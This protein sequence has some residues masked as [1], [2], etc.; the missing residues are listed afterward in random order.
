MKSFH[1]R[2]AGT[3]LAALMVVGGTMAGASPAV[4]AKDNRVSITSVSLSKGSV[5][6]VVVEFSYSCDL[7]DLPF[8][9]VATAIGAT[10]KGGVPLIASFT[11]PQKDAVCD[12]NVE[13]TK[14]VTLRQQVGAGSPRVTG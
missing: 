5:P 13:H 4:A 3:A 7:G 9:Y 14:R 1:S 11:V 12:D 2:L 6:S 10:P 8:N